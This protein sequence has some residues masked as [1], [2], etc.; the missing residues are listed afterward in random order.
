MQHLNRWTQYMPFWMWVGLIQFSEGMSRTK[1]REKKNSPFSASYSSDWPGISIFCSFPGIYTIGSL[2][3][4]PSYLHHPLCWVSTLKT[5][6]HG[7][8]HTDNHMNRCHIINPIYIYKSIFYWLYFSGEPWIMY[9]FQLS[10]IVT[11]YDMLMLKNFSLLTWNLKY[12]SC[13]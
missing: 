6:H 2:V 4:K 12:A 5:A 13:V 3:L 1:W 11:A 8:S 7:T 9:S 10:P